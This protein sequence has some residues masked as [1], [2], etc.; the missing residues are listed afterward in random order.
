MSTAST[1]KLAYVMVLA[2]GLLTVGGAI[3]RQ[4][5]SPSH[6]SPAGDSC[7]AQALDQA[8]ERQPRLDLHGDPLPP[9]ALARLGTLQQ[10]APKSQIALSAD[11]KEII[12]VDSR[13]LARRFEFSTGKLLGASQ[14]H[15]EDPSIGVWPYRLSPRGTYVLTMGF[16]E[17]NSK[18]FELWHVASG[19]LVQSISLGDFVASAEESMAFS[20]DESL[21]ALALTNPTRSNHKTVLWNL[22]TFKTREVWDLH[23]RITR[24]Y[25]EPFVTFSPDGKRVVAG[26][27]D[28]A[29]RCWEVENGKLRW[30]AK[31]QKY[32]SELVFFSPDGKRL[33]CPVQGWK[34]LDA[35]TGLPTAQ[36]LRPPRE[37]LFPVGFTPDGHFLACED[38]YGGMVLWKP[39]DKKIASSFPGPSP[40]PK[41]LWGISRIPTDFAFTRD[42]KELIRKSTALQRW[43]LESGKPRYADT[44]DWGHTEAV[45]R[46]VFSPDGRSLASSSDDNTLRVWDLATSGT[47]LVLQKWGDFLSFTRDG[48]SLFASP[49]IGA[50]EKTF[51]RQWNLSNGQGERDFPEPPDSGLGRSNRNQEVR[52]SPDG[53]RIL[54][55]SAKNGRRGDECI[56]LI[57]EAVSGKNLECK[58]VPWLPDSVLLPDGESVVAVDSRTGIVRTVELTKAEPRLEFQTDRVANSNE[59]P[60]GCDLVVSESGRLMSAHLQLMTRNQA[61]GGGFDDIR[62]G[63]MQT[64]RQLF[65]IPFPRKAA[66]AFSPNDRQFA[67]AAADKIRVWD[68]RSWRELGV[69]KL[70]NGV[71]APGAVQAMAFSP[72]GRT[73][74]TGHADSTILI[75]E[76]R[77]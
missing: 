70:G 76:N 50:S 3:A 42:G 67:V 74:A 16:P 19:N 34:F 40:R 73:I 62:V 2:C 21:A 72:K 71:M 48:K 68:T 49:R 44:A 25:H 60:F 5:P 58:R 41:D 39:G 61:D 28:L 8:S 10:R 32:Y 69:I 65:K 56:L 4:A 9:G 36:E 51:L 17:N 64:G 63:D 27:Y 46:L 6:Q 30:E 77:F 22:K 1:L 13:L 7:E 23:E 31:D 43:E 38:G 18:Q 33:F 37:A 47:S 15:K 29:L 20:A 24:F 57:W 75:W 35:D 45:T 26:H 12:A 55:L 54:L 11:G 66:M 52:M 14:I 59:R 53:R